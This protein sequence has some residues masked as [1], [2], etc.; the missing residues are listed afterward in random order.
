MQ[1]ERHRVVEDRVHGQGEEGHEAEKDERDLNQHDGNLP[2]RAHG[3]HRRRKSERCV[4]INQYQRDGEKYEPEPPARREA[5]HEGVRLEAKILYAEA[6]ENNLGVKAKNARWT[7]WF[8]CSLCEQDYHGVVA[9]ALGWACWKTYEGRL[10]TDVTR[11]MAMSLLGSGLY[12]AKHYE[13]ALSVGEAE[14]AILQRVGAPENHVL[15]A[16]SNL[17]STYEK[18]GRVDEALSLRKEVY[19]K[20][21]K[22]S[23]EEDISTIIAANN[24]GESLVNLGRYHE[25]KSLLRKTL[26]VARRVLGE[27]NETTLRLRARCAMALYEDPAATL[28]AL[29]EAVTT[30]EETERIARRVLGGAHPI[31]VVLAGNIPKARAKLRARE[32]PPTNG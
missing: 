32:A 12:R 29:R 11:R 10:E 13:D 21:L 3:A 9:C 31:T 22:R 5:V 20:R 7:R 30:L 25:A 28:D 4:V 27:G 15:A 14:L 1:P 19:S 2:E 16:Q 17:A 6:E 8:T 24:Y 18:A 23:G 26:P